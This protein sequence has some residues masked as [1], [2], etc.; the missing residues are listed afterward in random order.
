METDLVE[1]LIRIIRGQRVILDADLA[2]VYGVPTKRLNEAVR[3]NAEKFPDDFAFELDLEEVTNLRSQIATSSGH[4]GR[5][6][7]PWVFTEH[8]AIM[9]ANV[10]NSPRAVQMS[11]FV[12]RAFVKMRETLAQNKQL[13]GKLAELE[14][15]LTA[16]L[17][18]QEQAIVHILG[19]IKKLMEPVPPDTESAPR[20]MG[21]HVKEEPPVYV[22]KPRKAKKS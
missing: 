10:L 3:R 12:V 5:R 4:G 16:R 6:Y 20:E 15:N 14:R 13:A 2:Q 8:G 19:E 11:V 1:S 22:S 7:R 9:A 18:D 17:D 21:F